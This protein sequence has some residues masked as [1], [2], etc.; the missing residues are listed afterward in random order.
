MNDRFL[1]HKNFV[2]YLLLSVVF[3]SFDCLISYFVFFNHLQNIIFLQIL[4][5]R[6]IFFVRF[7]L[8]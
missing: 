1:E 3:F 8:L 6:D 4:K 7:Y 5:M 2:C